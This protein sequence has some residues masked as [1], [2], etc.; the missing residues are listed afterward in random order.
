M[1]LPWRVLAGTLAT[2]GVSIGASFF[3]M[4][5]DIQF[6]P[7]SS[8]DPIF[9]SIYHKKSNPNGN[10][11]I[12]DLHVKRVP[13]SKIDPTLLE[14]PQKLLERYCGGVW[15]GGG[16]TPQRLAL[17]WFDRDESTSQLWSRSELI[18]SEYTVGTDIV[19]NFEVIDRSKESILIRGGD[20]TSNQGLRPLDGLIEVT[21]H[22]E[23]E[24]DVAE[25]GFKSLF[26]QGVGTTDQLPMPGPAI[27]LHE[28][29]AKALLRSGV[30]HVLK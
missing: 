14:H 17:A 28:Q 2:G 19:G 30:Q 21:V 8:S 22:I 18:Q 4:T 13:L 1:P 12:R 20:R 27:W 11:T 3:Y 5:H 10:P 24:Q 26:F 25:F 15:A 23:K 29:Y 9:L 16:F 6:V 7:L